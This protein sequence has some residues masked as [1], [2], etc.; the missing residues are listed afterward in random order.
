MHV[1]AYT[2]AG[3]HAGTVAWTP[4]MLK[5]R[6]LFYKEYEKGALSAEEKAK[7][8]AELPEQPDAPE[9]VEFLYLNGTRE[10]WTWRR[11]GSTNAAFIGD[12]AREDFR[13]FF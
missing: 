8:I 2:Y 13:R 7:T 1:Y 5:I 6:D 12:R 9:F 3:E 11:N 4:L 10:G